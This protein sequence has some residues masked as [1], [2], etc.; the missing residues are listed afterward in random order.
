MKQ[1]G[2]KARI[3]SIIHLEEVQ[4]AVG[5]LVRRGLLNKRLHERWR[6][7]RDTNKDLPE[8][9][10]IVVV[11]MPHPI[12]RVRFKYEGN[13]YPADI[14]P[15]YFVSAAN[16]SSAEA[17]LNK[18]LKADGYRVAR[19]HL[20]LKTLAVRSGLAQYGRNN[21][22]YVS[23]MGSLCTLVAFYTDWVGE[24]DNWQESKAMAAC[25]NCS[26]CRE[27]CPTGSIS[28]DRF[29][30]HA[31]NCLGFL[32]E[33]K[34]S[35][36]YWVQLQPDWHN[37]LMGCMRCQFVCPVDK[38]YLRKIEEGPSF[39]EE[40][41]DLMLNKTPW[42]GLSQETRRKLRIPGALY[43]RMVPNLSARIEKQSK[44]E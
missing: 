9:K 6:F 33:M 27:N 39:S 18:A 44:Q 38:P 35:F 2:Y 31:E 26:L 14:P 36:P 7:Y 4:E 13:V 1:C 23:G 16:E 5:G 22:A 25:E 11:A 12:T 40:E 24:E 41:T 32:Q 20:A 21:I 29:L 10:T 19:A 30:I 42:E 15:D 37:A 3:V 28:A 43:P 34:P 17:I 8:A